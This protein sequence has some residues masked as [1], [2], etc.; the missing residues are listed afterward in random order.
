MAD[1]LE[2]VFARF[3][4]AVAPTFRPAPVGELTRRRGRRAWTGMVAGAL[5]LLVGAPVGALTLAGSSSDAAPGPLERD[6]GQIPLPDWELRAPAQ[7]GYANGTIWAYAD[8]GCGEDVCV[9]SQLASS[10][11]L[12]LTWQI[13]RGGDGYT[14]ATLFVSPRGNVFLREAGA[15]SIAQVLPETGASILTPAVPGPPELLLELGG[16]LILECPGQ[17]TYGG[18][19]ALACDRPE[20]TD[21]TSIVKP[22]VPAGMGRLTQLIR[23]GAGR[24]WL[25][26]RDPD[27]RRYRVSSS[28]DGGRTWDT[29]V[30]RE[31]PADDLRLTVSAIDGDAWVVT[32]APVRV[33]R[34]T[35]D[36]G[37]LTVKDGEGATGAWSS[38]AT[39]SM[40]RAVGEGA[41]IAATP[42]DGSWLLEPGLGQLPLEPAFA[43]VSMRTFPDGAVILR[44]G[45][46][47]VGVGVGRGW[48]RSWAWPVP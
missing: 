3:E 39:A 36:G 24:T 22:E 46:G 35:H 47:H 48:N 12:G 19:E 30:E 25:L 13:R 44:N 5:V 42:A 31:S 41:L 10:V 21:L 17:E 8:G 43:T 32:A 33:W 9:D 15:E 2:D 37:T 11:D 18:Q 7:F 40:L 16:D 6:I 45:I 14:H 34:L 29:P 20:V 26:G 4:A 1:H 23:D 38:T 28:A 27:S